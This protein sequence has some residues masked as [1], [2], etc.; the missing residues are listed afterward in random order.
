MVS[1]IESHAMAGPAAST[2]GTIRVEGI[3]SFAFEHDH[4]P[5]D[6]S[7]DASEYAGSQKTPENKN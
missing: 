4:V 5:M 2:R 6:V 3:W 1:Q 7:V